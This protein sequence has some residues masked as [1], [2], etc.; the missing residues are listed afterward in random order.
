MPVQHKYYFIKKYTY[1]L[2]TTGPSA[3]GLVYEKNKILL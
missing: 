3:G 1:P 2:N